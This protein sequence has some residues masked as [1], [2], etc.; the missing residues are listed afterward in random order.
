[1]K[2]W[3]CERVNENRTAAR[4]RLAHNMPAPRDL[5]ALLDSNAA[6]AVPQPGGTEVI[7]SR[8][9]FSLQ[10]TCDDLRRELDEKMWQPLRER[11]LLS[12]TLFCPSPETAN[13][14]APQ[15]TLRSLRCGLRSRE[16]G[17]GF[18][19]NCQP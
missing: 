15:I 7:R 1:M 19:T 13:S 12:T 3:W 2:T 8:L 16:S 10:H 4:R 5:K 9:R 18:P 11:K 17:K 14:R 6:A